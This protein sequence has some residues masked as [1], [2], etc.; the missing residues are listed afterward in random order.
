MF[1]QKDLTQI[2]A[3]HLTLND[4]IHQIERYRLGTD[5]ADVV[6]AASI[7]NGI[8]VISEG[9]QEA[10]IHLYDRCKEDLDVVKFVPASGAATRMFRFLH[11]FLNEYDPKKQSLS[12]FLKSDADTK[13]VTFFDRINSFPFIN[14]VRKQIRKQF[15]DYKQSNKGERAVKLVTAMLKEDGLG[16]EN[17]PKG[18]IPFHKYKKFARTAFEEQLYEGAWYAATQGETRLHFT[19]S[20]A[21]VSK[22]KKRFEKIKSRL[23]KKAHTQFSIS[24]SFQKPETNHIV[25][26]EEDQPFRNEKGEL[27]FRPSG[28]GALLDNLNDI[29]ADIIFIKNIDNVAAAEYVDTIA[30]Q[31]KMLAGKLLWIQQKCFDYIKTIKR[32]DITDALRNEIK[33]FLWQQLNIKDMPVHLKDVVNLLNRPIRVCGVVKNT[34]APGGGPFWVKNRN[35]DLSVQ[36]VETAQIDLSDAHQRTLVQDATHFNPVD[37]VCGVRDYE[38][39]KF[40]LQAFVNPDTGFITTKT[41][42]GQPVRVMERPGLWNGAMAHWNTS[43]VEVPII[44][45]N[46]VKNVNDLLQRTHRP[47]A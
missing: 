10:L 12:E 45:F 41:I 1:T 16:Y 27:V 14:K 39:N 26:N 30:A 9:N 24:Y 7:G 17:L 31:K 33:T 15:P 21:H 43:F 44:T 4:V 13:L 25:L 42:D 3:Q 23:E 40:D 46:P 32:G 36:I 2:E 5:H 35:G 20:E 47:N 22:F 34:G 37:I 29:D 18:L 11:T 8:E 38:G 28:H 19:F 6:T